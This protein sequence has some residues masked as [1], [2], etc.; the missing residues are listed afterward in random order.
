MTEFFIWQL[1]LLSW[2]VIVDHNRKHSVEKAFSI[3]E[4]GLFYFQSW[5]QFSVQ[6]FREK[7]EIVF[8]MLETL[9]VKSLIIQDLSKLIRAPYR[10]IF[11]FSSLKGIFSHFIKNRNINIATLQCFPPTDCYPIFINEGIHHFVKD[12]SRERANM[13]FVI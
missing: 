6:N 10:V 12:F 2:K 3:L 8:P 7:L 13:V 1:D 9:K 11:L 4:T 5:K